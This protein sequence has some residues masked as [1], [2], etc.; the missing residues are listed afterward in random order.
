M[1][2]F[3]QRMNQR[4][5][6]QQGGKEKTMAPVFKNSFKEI[7]GNLTETPGKKIYRLHY[8]KIASMNTSNLILFI[9][10]CNHNILPNLRLEDSRAW[11]CKKSQELCGM[12]EKSLGEIQ[13]CGGYYFCPSCMDYLVCRKCWES[14]IG[15]CK[16]KRMRKVK[17]Y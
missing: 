5:M 6:K 14:K 7:V 13:D 9:L 17:D 8:T 11:I 15:L 1:K 2:D 4:P 12:C 3:S 16:A 10:D